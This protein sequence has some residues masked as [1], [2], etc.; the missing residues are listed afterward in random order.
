MAFYTDVAVSHMV[1]SGVGGICD[2][3]EKGTTPTMLV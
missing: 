1:A 3:A 2:M